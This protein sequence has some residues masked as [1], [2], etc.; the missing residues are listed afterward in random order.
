MPPRFEIDNHAF[1]TGRVIG[2]LDQPVR[3]AIFMAREIAIVSGW[4]LAPSGIRSVEVFVDGDPRGRI[5]DGA[6]RPDIAKRRRQYDNA[7]H[8]G[9]S[10]S[11][12]LQGLDECSHEL[13]I[14][15]TANDGQTF[16][17]PTRIE[18][19]SH[20][21]IDAGMPAINRH[22]R[23][24]LDRR[25][26]KAE[27]E[28]KVPTAASVRL[29]IVVPVQGDCEEE[30]E[31]L[32]TS[33]EAQTHPDWRLTLIETSDASEA[34]RALLAD[35]ASSDQRIHVRQVEA[36]DVVNAINTAI[37]TTD[38]PWVAMLSPGVI[39][40]VNALAAIAGAASSHPEA[41]II[42]PD[43]DRIDPARAERWNPFF[44]PDW[45]PDLLLSMNYFGPLTFLARD[46]VLASG[47]LR[48]GF[49]GAEIYD[50]SL[51]ITERGGEVIHIPDVLVST[52]DTAPAVG[53]SWHAS[54]WRESE[55]SALVDT[56]RRR[57][58]A[59]SVERVVIPGPGGF[60]TTYQNR[61]V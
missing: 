26:A 10:G 38:A 52:I 19:D 46:Q 6:L 55:R 2:R 35:L 11:I 40:P 29:E 32:A 13:L 31:V 22:Y 51:R 60:D 4:A 49:P 36:G 34:V 25:A 47:G 16:E 54:D 43:D 42:Y 5:A 15:V 3:G 37:A 48:P 27:A 28:R 24:W 7:D 53:E 41:A 21:A 8:C 45:S 23:A 44:K 56:L 58:V 39:L 59:G 14:L 12:P 30:L 20:N 50:L 17:L 1:E 9:F 57:A 18:I 33:I 61:P